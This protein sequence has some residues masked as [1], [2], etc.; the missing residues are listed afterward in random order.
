MGNVSQSEDVENGDLLVK[1]VIENDLAHVKRVRDDLHY[2]LEI[3]LLDAIFG[4]VKEVNTWD[5]EGS[6][7]QVVISPGVQVDEHI[8]FK[9]KGFYNPDLDKTE[10]NRG[11][12]V[13]NLNVK[14]P[15][16]EDFSNKG[17]MDLKNI[18]THVN[19]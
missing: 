2:T 4:C 19:I 13:I 7:E 5:S 11:N 10:L 3:S 18:L 16:P 14:I 15:S 6:K 9:H 8:I 1:V 12:L 17:K